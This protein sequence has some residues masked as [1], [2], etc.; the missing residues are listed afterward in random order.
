MFVGGFACSQHHFPAR[1]RVGLGPVA[2]AARGNG[3]A[4]LGRQTVRYQRAVGVTG[5]RKLLLSVCCKRDRFALI[6][7]GYTMHT[8]TRTDFT[9]AFMFLPVVI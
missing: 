5:T 7:E 1:R 2:A 8:R 3:A 4:A 6:I 9:T